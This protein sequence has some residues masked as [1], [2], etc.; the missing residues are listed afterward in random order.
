VAVV[1]A[2]WLALVAVDLRAAAQAGRHGRDVLAGSTL[3]GGDIASL[4]AATDSS[5]AAD[6]AGGI[7]DARATLESA[8]A[9]FSEAERRL[10][11][12]AVAPLKVLPF[13]GRQIRAVGEV[14]AAA[15]QISAAS[16]EAMGE[17]EVLAASPTTDP[18]QRVEA[19]GDTITVLEGLAADLARVD[20][21]PDRALVSQVRELHESASEQVAE[22]ESSVESAIIGLQGVGSFLTGPTTYLVLAANNAEMRAGSGMFLQ[23]GTV[24]VDQGRFELSDFT[25]TADMFL[26][27][28][29]TTLD[30]DM[31]ARWG[32]LQPDREWRNL[33]M[34]P[35]FD[36]S[37][38]MAA[39]MWAASGRGQ[40]DGVIAVD[41]VTVQRLLE[42]TGPVDVTTST[43]QVVTYDSD[44]V[45][46]LL[47]REQY[48]TDLAP[49][50]RRDELG[51][52]ASAVFDAFNEREIPATGLVSLI[53]GSGA[54]RHLLMWSADPVQQRSWEELG[55][56]GELPPE[57]LMLA[58]LNRGG[59]K[60]DPYMTVTADLDVEGVEAGRRRV[61][62]EVNMRNDA[63]EWLPP[64]VAGP[65]EGSGGVAG[66]YVGI[67][68]LSVPKSATEPTTS[69]NGWAVIGEDGPTRV[70]GSNVAIPR[71]TSLTV[72]FGFELPEWEDELVVV[73]GA[74]EPAT[75]WTAGQMRWTEQRPTTVPLDGFD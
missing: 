68:A 35:R 44:N 60:L 38:R 39:D 63:P 6:P 45:V 53:T 26:S 47:A 16:A 72:T 23:N 69:A 36:E 42:L 34:S 20:L 33:N 22:L 58:L 5:G 31:A 9:D 30:P 1:A 15:A 17:L 14:T 75:S 48:F 28:S 25:P 21:G 11:S 55:I 66:E 59:N 62:V 3:V 54:Q 64:Y 2:I 67:L 27:E 41:I 71:G 29:G 10:G 12:P 4:V 19:V 32:T 65:V 24:T 37:A 40:V 7:T 8:N 51:T 43:G 52:V 73:P 57:A 18:S 74:R 46:A 13:V 50:D 56:A 70:I 61:T 49:E